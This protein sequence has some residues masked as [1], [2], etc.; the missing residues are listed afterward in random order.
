MRLSNFFQNGAGFSLL[1]LR[2]HDRLVSHRPS[3]SSYSIISS[4]VI[5]RPCMARHFTPLI[6]HFLQMDNSLNLNINRGPQFEQDGGSGNT[7]FYASNNHYYSAYR[8]I[9]DPCIYKAEDSSTS[10][11]IEINVCNNVLKMDTMER[12][13]GGKDNKYDFIGPP[14]YENK[15]NLHLE[16]PGTQQGDDPRY[17]LKVFIINGSKRFTAL[18][19][20]VVSETKAVIQ[21]VS[22]LFERSGMPIK[23]K[24]TGLL[25]FVH[26]VVPIEES[27]LPEFIKIAQRIRYHP[28]N[29]RLALGQADVAIFLENIPEETRNVVKAKHGYSFYAGAATLSKSYAVVLSRPGESKTFIAKKI[30]HEL[31]H[32]LGVHH[33]RE[34]GFI[35]EA[36]S[37]ANCENKER[38]FSPE[39]VAE[40]VRF[41]GKHRDVFSEN[42]FPF[43]LD[44]PVLSIEAANEFVKR[45]RK[46]SFMDIVESRLHGIIPENA[47]SLYYLLISLGI[48]IACVLLAIYYLC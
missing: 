24:F 30:A 40:V 32:L 25:N 29:L 27:P 42:A 33:D 9:E 37:C 47:G 16:T 44:G 11:A 28:R 2:S 39:S 34:P 26:N 23:I 41:M 1:H 6:D 17:D 43:D 18:S 36:L 13:F 45:Q 19:A 22:D 5:L 31:A 3:S 7:N 14:K 10:E 8:V 15:S 20:S 46:H 4:G 35:M 12:V 48:Y 38:L 21:E